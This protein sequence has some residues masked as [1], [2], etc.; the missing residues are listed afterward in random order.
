[1]ADILSTR[2]RWFGSLS[3]RHRRLGRLV[4]DE[5]EHVRSCV[6]AG[7][8]EVELAPRDLIQIDVGEQDLLAVAG[9]PARTS[10]SGLMMQLPPVP[11]DIIGSLLGKR[12]GDS[13]RGV[14]AARELVGAESTK[15][16]SLERDVRIVDSHVSRLSAVGAQ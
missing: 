14:G 4:D 2:I 12:L 5:P 13:R 1:M 6:V 10:P 16:S 9:G 11:K 8:I 3:R 7:D 15:Q